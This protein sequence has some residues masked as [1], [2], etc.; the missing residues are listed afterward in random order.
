MKNKAKILQLM[1]V[2]SLIMSLSTI[3]LYSETTFFFKDVEDSDW[4]YEDLSQLVQI[5]AINGYTDG[6]FRP[7]KTISVAEFI[8]ITLVA[9]NQKLIIP[10]GQDWYSKYIETALAQNYIDVNYY[11][12]YLRPITRGEMGDIIDRVLKLSYVGTDNYIAKIA[13]YNEISSCH[14]LSMVDVYIAGIMTGYPDNTIRSTALATRSEASAVIIRMIDD[15]K[16]I[17]PTLGVVSGASDDALGTSE[18]SAYTGSN[19][20]TATKAFSF[21]NVE[22]GS[23]KSTL[24]S[25]YGTP[26]EI[27]PNQY[28]YEWYV[29]AGDY[30]QFKLIGVKDEKVVALFSNVHMDS[31]LGINIGTSESE[32]Q[33]KLK[34]SEYSD[35]YYSIYEGLNIQFFSQKDVADGVEGI[36]VMDSAAL[37]VQN[38]S[39][40][41]MISLEKVIYHL[42]NGARVSHGIQPLVWSEK[43]RTTAYS[44]SKDMAINNYF[45][46]D[47][48]NGDS[49]KER[50]IKG[51]IA[52]SYYAENIAAGYQN[53]FEIHSALMHSSGHRKNIL[54]TQVDH[55]GVGVYYLATSKYKYYITEDFYKAQ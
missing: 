41:T 30:K 45:A 37:P 52:G 51:G 43:S 11:N 5:G 1:L 18:L 12:D 4:F 49:S 24:I 13:D 55:L 10:K 39:N 7:L 32:L 2:M 23:T 48:L 27:L 16:R 21:G 31:N 47:S 22:I 28:G 15:S 35:Y 14:K 54:N 3:Q 36:L 29:Y 25:R 19:N 40:Q 26:N 44:H 50:M 42:I 17:P 46:H 53:P 9:S 33:K 6:S 38:P 20:L 8:K 34:V